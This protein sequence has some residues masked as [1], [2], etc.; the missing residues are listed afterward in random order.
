MRKTENKT[1]PAQ[2]DSKMSNLV[3]TP[4]P[5]R[6]LRLNLLCAQPDSGNSKLEMRQHGHTEGTEITK[7]GIFTMRI[8]N[9]WGC[10]RGKR[11][12]ESMS[13]TQNAL[14]Q[15][16]SKMSNGRL[17]G[18]T[19][20][21]QPDSKMSNGQLSGVSCWPHGRQGMSIMQVKNNKPFFASVSPACYDGGVRI[22]SVIITGA[23]GD[24]K[25]T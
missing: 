21:A 16:D 18:K 2:H 19:V 11:G 6:P 17:S 22:Q 24:G 10:F 9:I 25:M 5:P 3:L 15:R 12:N 4:S 14:P 23:R 20:P 7:K 8:K 1:R 13:K